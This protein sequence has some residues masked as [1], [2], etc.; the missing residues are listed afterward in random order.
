MS[1]PPRAAILIFTRG[2]ASEGARKQLHPR[3][4]ADPLGTI[5]DTLLAQACAGG[6]EVVVA[7]PEG[8]RLPALPAS[9][10]RIRQ[11]GSGSAARLR[12]AMADV[13]ARGVDGLVVIGDDAPEIRSDDLRSALQFISGSAPTAVVG[14]CRD[15]GFYLLALNRSAPDA[16]R[17][18]PWG[19][20][21]ARAALQ[22][23]LRD[24][25]FELHLLRPL[26]D[27]DDRVG[28]QR[29]ATRLGRQRLASL[30]ELQAQIAIWIRSACAWMKL[31]AGHP[32]DAL[33]SRLLPSR[34]PPA[35]PLSS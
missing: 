23:R 7:A 2:P 19:S 9:V 17:G 4:G 25:G 13:F 1:G 26:A 30:R 10:S 28:L 20:R 24:S 12:R 5:F 16:L 29:L 31:P 11:E 22:R 8:A 34:A 14:P 32:R 27:L 33:V 15:G 35:S 3:G 18:I 21:R 6:A